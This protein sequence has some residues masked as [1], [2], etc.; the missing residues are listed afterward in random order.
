M[1]SQLYVALDNGYISSDEFK[2]LSRL[3]GDCSVLIWRLIQSLKV[4]KF[5]G[6]QF[7]KRK[8]EREKWNEFLKEQWPQEYQ[9]LKEMGLIEG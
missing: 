2:R 6:L 5:A 7:K 1:R 3:S 8:S 4:S 9:R